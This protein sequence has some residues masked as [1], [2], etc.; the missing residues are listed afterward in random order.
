MALTVTL[1]R[2]SVRAAG[3]SCTSPSGLV[4]SCTRFV[5]SS[6]TAWPPRPVAFASVYQRV[7]LDAVGHAPADAEVDAV[8]ARLADAHVHRRV[9][10]VQRQI[11]VAARTVPAG[12]G[13]ARVERPAHAEVPAVGVGEVDVEHRRPRELVRPADRRLPR[14]RLADLRRRDVRAV[15]RPVRVDLVQRGDVGDRLAE[16]EEAAVGVLDAGGVVHVEHDA[17]SALRA[18]AGEQDV[19]VGEAVVVVDAPAGADDVAA[20]AAEVVDAR[21]CAA[22]S[23]SCPPAPSCRTRRTRERRRSGRPPRRRSARC[24]SGIVD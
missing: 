9:G 2:A 21:R 7:H 23:C 14:E 19:G 15:E 22:A 6:S 20:V 17:R 13:D 5:V 24:S 18:Q 11:G 16:R 10:R 12:N 3:P 1:C 8:V 4:E